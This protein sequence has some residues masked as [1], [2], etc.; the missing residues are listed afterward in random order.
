MSVKVFVKLYLNTIYPE[1]GF[2]IGFYLI[3]FWLT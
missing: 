3:G 1:A 2:K